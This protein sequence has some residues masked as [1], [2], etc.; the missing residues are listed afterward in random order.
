MLSSQAS[1][2]LMLVTYLSK[3]VYFPITDWKI[4]NTFIVAILQQ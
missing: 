4:R 3:Y 2:F 1:N